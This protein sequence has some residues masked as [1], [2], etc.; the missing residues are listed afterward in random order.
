MTRCSICGDAPDC[1]NSVA[2]LPVQVAAFLMFFSGLTFGCS[3][4]F[5]AHVAGCL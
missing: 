5:M 3:M 1:D 4:T 2:P